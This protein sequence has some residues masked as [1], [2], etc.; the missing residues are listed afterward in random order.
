MPIP[1]NDGHG[2]SGC[3]HNII[4][5]I[6]ELIVFEVD[7][8]IQRVLLA[9]LLILHDLGLTAGIGSLPF[10]EVVIGLHGLP[11]LV[12]DFLDLGLEVLEVPVDGRLRLRGQHFPFFVDDLDVGVGEEIDLHPL[13]VHDLLDP[14]DLDHH[15]R[16]ELVELLLE[17]LIHRLEIVDL[18]LLQQEGIL[19]T[20]LSVEHALDLVLEEGVVLLEVTV[21]GE[22]RRLHL[23]EVFLVA[24]HRREGGTGASSLLAGSEHRG[25]HS[26]PTD[27]PLQGHLL[28][29][30]LPQGVEVLLWF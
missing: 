25:V 20:A 8:V 18:L 11:A 22:D 29:R 6:L 10:L 28:F 27:V 23:S 14:L 26:R 9:Q 4:D 5:I 17:V 15:F 19:E 21:L 1:L 16:D 3:E 2:E 12:V 24:G 7:V 13:L 30:L